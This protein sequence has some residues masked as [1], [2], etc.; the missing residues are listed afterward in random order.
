MWVLVV[1]CYGRRYSCGLTEGRRHIKSHDLTYR[2]VDVIKALAGWEGVV[3]IDVFESTDCQE[4]SNRRS[5]GEECLRVK[6]QLWVINGYLWRNSEAFSIW[7]FLVSERHIYSDMKDFSDA[8]WWAGNRE[9]RSRWGKEQGAE[10]LCR[11]RWAQTSCVVWGCKRQGENHGS[12]NHG[13]MVDTLIAYKMATLIQ[14]LTGPGL[15]SRETKCIVES[16]SANVKP[17]GHYVR[18][19]CP[20]AIPP[21]V[22]PGKRVKERSRRVML[23]SIHL[24]ALKHY[25]K[26]Q[27]TQNWSFPHLLLSPGSL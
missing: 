25:L 24:S 26:R 19:T 27:F 11:S 8:Q 17:W 7:T 16:S 10:H 23:G 18:H 6:S 15:L 1:M 21:L 14:S 13:T 3:W 4:H 12:L 9:H 20:L 22:Y 5:K 2:V